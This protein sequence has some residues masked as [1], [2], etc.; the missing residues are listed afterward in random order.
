MV[1][2]IFICLGWLAY[3]EGLFGG[4]SLF[5]RDWL[6]NRQTTKHKRMPAWY[7]LVFLASIIAWPITVP[8]LFAMIWLGE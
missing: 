3:I 6:D 1:E 7:Y 8:I 2:N 5:S 4:F